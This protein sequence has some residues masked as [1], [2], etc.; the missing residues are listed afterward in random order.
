VI[1]SVIPNGV[2]FRAEVVAAVVVR[3]GEVLL[4][5]RS[6]NREWYP[7]VWDLPVWI[8]EEWSGDPVNAAPKEHD[9]VEWVSAETLASLALADDSFPSLIARALAVVH[10]GP[11]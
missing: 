4:C 8:L 6:P 5:H 1:V 3:D 9:V 7:N 2:S 10:N 11:S